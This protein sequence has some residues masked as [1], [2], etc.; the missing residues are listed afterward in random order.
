MHH[1]TSHWLVEQQ[2]LYQPLNNR[3]SENI[4]YLEMHKSELTC[5]AD[6]LHTFEAIHVM[7]GMIYIA[8]IHSETYSTMILNNKVY[9]L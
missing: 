4:S 7:F 3:L 9:D 8:Y 1:T 6:K 5:F 2:F